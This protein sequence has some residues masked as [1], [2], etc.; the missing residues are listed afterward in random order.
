MV[1][2][3]TQTNSAKRHPAS[4]LCAEQRRP[5]ESPK[6]QT[7]SQTLPP[8]TLQFQPGFKEPLSTEQPW[9]GIKSDDSPDPRGKRATRC[10]FW[11]LQLVRH[12]QPEV[13][14]CLPVSRS[15]ALRSVQ[16]V[17]VERFGVSVEMTLPILGLKV[18]VRDD[19]ADAPEVEF[20]DL[21]F[22][23]SHHHPKRRCRRVQKSMPLAEGSTR[24]TAPRARPGQRAAPPGMRRR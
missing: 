18:T 22:Q 8:T 23:L 4:L 21:F 24:W 11:N 16:R 13:H 1:A 9:H 14:T 12:L 17:L 10:W 2:E 6:W 7:L 15:K 5:S 19:H 3:Y 20:Q